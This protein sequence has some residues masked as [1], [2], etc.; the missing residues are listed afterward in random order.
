M[1]WS[2]WFWILACLLIHRK[3]LGVIAAHIIA[4]VIWCSVI[5]LWRLFTIFSMVH[6][7]TSLCTAHWLSSQTALNFIRQETTLS[8]IS[9][10]VIDFQLTLAVEGSSTCRSSDI[11]IFYTGERWPEFCLR[12]R[13]LIHLILD[14]RCGCCRRGLL[15][16]F[17][18]NWGEFITWCGIKSDLFNC[19]SIARSILIRNLSLVFK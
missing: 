9:S 11:F 14:A 6:K 2:L 3:S 12:W 19:I 15:Y 18:S 1:L 4:L 10:V 5:T 13:I 7:T 17:Y 16:S 8:F